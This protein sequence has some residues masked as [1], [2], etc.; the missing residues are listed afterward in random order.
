MIIT[1]GAIA[2]NF[3]R[4]AGLFALLFLDLCAAETVGLPTYPQTQIASRRRARLQRILNPIDK[5]IAFFAMGF[6][7]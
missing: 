1:D 7:G 5:R 2:A 6:E 4:L 3:L